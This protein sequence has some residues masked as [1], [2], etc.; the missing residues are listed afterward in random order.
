MAADALSRCFALTSAQ[1]QESF[2]HELQLLQSQDPIYG[3]MM[4]KLQAA[5]NP[6]SG[7]S[8][9]QGLL[10]WKGRLVIPDNAN[11]KQR[12]L[13]DFHHSLLGGHAGSLRTYM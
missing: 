1:T 11:L 13:Q 4:V 5:G 6:N 9:R 2:L 8:L 10:C 12:L 3:P 7:Y